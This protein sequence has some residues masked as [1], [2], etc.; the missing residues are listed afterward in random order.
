MSLF[1]QAN[2]FLASTLAKSVG[3]NVTYKRGD[4]QKIVKAWAGRTLFSSIDRGG[5]GNYVT[6]SE[7]DYMLAISEIFEEFGEPQEDD[8]IL[9]NI[10]G[11]EIAFVVSVPSGVTDPPWRYIDSAREIVRI[12]T[13]RR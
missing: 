5:F 3:T 6:W 11:E 12:H 7:R 4:N 13:K 8:I 9:E 2:F 10:N 1:K